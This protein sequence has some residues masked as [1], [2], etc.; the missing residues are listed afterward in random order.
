[1]SRVFHF[2][3]PLRH[4]LVL[5]HVTLHERAGLIVELR[6]SNG[7]IG[8]GECSP[9]P[10]FFRDSLTDCTE[11]LS[12]HQDELHYGEVS[13]A[14]PSVQSALDQARLW[15]QCKKENR[16]PLDA[17]NIKTRVLSVNALLT[18]S[19][20]EVLQRAASCRSEGFT[21]AKLKIGRGRVSDDLNLVRM[22]REIL[23][24]EI[25]LRL[26]AN[27]SWSYDDGLEFSRA[28]E[29]SGI[30]Y[31]EEP[32]ADSSQLAKLITE[33]P[34]ARIALD[35]SFSTMGMDALVHFPA[36][37]AIILRPQVLGGIAVTRKFI[38]CFAQRG[39]TTV[40]SS[41]IESSLGLMGVM[42]CA[43][44]VAE[45]IRPAGLDTLSW[46]GEDSI[47]P[48]L[49]ISQGAMVWP[50]SWDSFAINEQVG[51]WHEL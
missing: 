50:A 12:N 22:V 3:I 13:E 10:G 51:V 40:I 38:H 36:P 2:R 46:L 8:Y 31:C 15:L 49:S 26:D 21:A 39:I 4:A 17:F 48:P 29:W 19:P 37:T 23:P 45:P 7:M 44:S 27:Q 43:L 32:L 42:F 33:I 25:S 18:G 28:V 14:P 6:D 35:E 20:E 1:M 11:W 34:A 24:A 30:E 41:A 47:V 9:L 5:R 16:S